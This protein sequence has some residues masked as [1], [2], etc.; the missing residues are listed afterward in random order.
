MST[1]FNIYIA[2]AVSGLFSSIGGAIVALIVKYFVE[3]HIQ[4]I[5]K[6]RGKK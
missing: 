5:K 6:T 2:L 4:K 1:D 3:P